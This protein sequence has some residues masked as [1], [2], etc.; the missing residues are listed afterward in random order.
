M[1]V[2]ATVVV[3]TVNALGLSTGCLPTPGPFEPGTVDTADRSSP[4]A[5]GD[6]FTLDAGDCDD[7][8]PEV[9]PGAAEV[10][11]GLD[12][13]CDG[14]VDDED[15]VVEG[16]TTIWYEDGDGDGFGTSD[17]TTEACDVPSGYVDNDRDCDDADTNLGDVDN[18]LDCDGWSTETDC[19]DDD[20]S[21]NYD[22]MDADGYSTCDDDC[23][24]SDDLINPGAEDG[25]LT[26]HDCDGE[27]TS[28]DLSLSDYTFLG[29]DSGQYLGRS[30]AA[31]GDVDGDGLADLLIGS[32]RNDEN[33][34]NTG[35]VYLIMG[36]S[37]GESPVIDLSLADYVFLGETALTMR[38][39]RYRQQVMWMAMVWTIF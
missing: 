21:Q 34:E 12:N 28:H 20:A 37:L 29:E 23:N 38:G 19:D 35:K 15:D 4:D 6:G 9:Y 18:D 17:V 30:V 2:R 31:A 8:D 1:V 39:G 14:L 36:A 24:D 11:D 7:G 27:F 13:D 32:H 22:D 25:L 26:D 10:C 33:G 16:T 5:D 3:F